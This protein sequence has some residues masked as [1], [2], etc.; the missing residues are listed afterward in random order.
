MVISLLASV[1]TFSEQ[2]Y[3]RRSYFCPLLQSKYST[4]TFSEE[5]FPQIRCLF[6]RSSF[7]RTVTSSQQLFFQNSYLFRVKLLPS[8]HFFRVRWLFRAVTCW[9]SYLFGGGIAQYKETYKRSSLLS[10]D[11]PFHSSQLFTTEFFRR[12]TILQLR[13][14]STPAF[15]IFQFV[16]KITWA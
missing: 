15:P 1:T 5:L 11:V 14:L 10:E 9:N 6:L 4:V 8:S 3:F 16:I 7:Y 2:F 12:D 13:F